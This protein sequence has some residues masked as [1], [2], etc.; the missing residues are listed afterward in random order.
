MIKLLTHNDNDLQSPVAKSR[1][2]YE[3]LLREGVAVWQTCRRI[4]ALRV[5]FDSY[6]EFH[7]SL[8]LQ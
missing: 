8:D 6:P 5:G 2:K 3:R 7:L 1:K 4:G